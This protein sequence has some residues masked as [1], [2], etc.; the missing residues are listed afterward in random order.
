[1]IFLSLDLCKENVDEF[2][3][4][5]EE[6]KNSKFDGVE[7]NLWG[8]IN[9]YSTKI[10]SKLDEVGLKVNVHTD[11]MRLEEGLEKVYEKFRYSLEFAKLV[12]ANKVITHPIKPYNETLEESKKLFDQFNNQSFLLE[13]VQGIRLPETKYFNL[14]LV[15]DIGS[16]TKNGDLDKLSDFENVGWL[17]LHDFRE[18]LDHYPI[19]EGVLDFKEILKKFNGIGCTIELG[20]VF[21]KWKDLNVNML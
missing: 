1:M 17:H 9:S 11:I 19:G 7:I 4:S 10:K 8:N 3:E 18:G 21:R 12:G 14:V 2:L 13:T 5:L 16:V 6:I 20:R 15:L